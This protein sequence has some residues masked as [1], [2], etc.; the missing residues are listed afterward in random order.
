[1]DLNARQ[2][3]HLKGLAHHLKPVVHLGKDGLSDAVVKQID[4]AL[5]DHELIKVRILEGAPFDRHEASSEVPGK[6]GA[7]L[8]QTIGKILVLYRPHPDDPRI[9]LPWPRREE[10]DETVPT[11]LAEARRPRAREPGSLLGSVRD[12]PTVPAQ[13]LPPRPPRVVRSEEPQGY[14]SATN[15]RDTRRDSRR[16]TPPAP[17][18]PRKSRP[19]A[20]GRARAKSAPRRGS[21]RRR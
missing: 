10:E 15:S 19:K 21:G 7:F 13:P 3:A 20:G 17:R 5:G 9:E 14:S 12:N 8:V 1:M 4:R 2:R 6:V 16:D 11:D 18:G